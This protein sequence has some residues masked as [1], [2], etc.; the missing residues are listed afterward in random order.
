MMP[1]FSAAILATYSGLELGI[2]FGFGFG[3]GFGLWSG[4]GLGIGLGLGF[5]LGLGLGWAAVLVTVSPS[6]FMWSRPT[7]V[8][9]HTRGVQWLVQSHRPPT[10]VSMTA[11]SSSAR[12]PLA[13][14]PTIVL[15]LSGDEWVDDL[16]LWM[17]EGTYQLLNGLASRQNTSTGWNNVVR[18]ALAGQVPRPA[19]LEPPGP[20]A[21]QPRLSPEASPWLLRRGGAGAQRVLARG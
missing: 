16:G 13:E 9:P 3:F 6:T 2:G 19:P 14:P 8:I 20:A 18:P 12:V 5:G 21:P 7:L 4:F 15:V 1:A 11:H 17:N 10:P